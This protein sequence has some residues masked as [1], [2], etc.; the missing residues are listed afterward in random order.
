MP[1][2][3]MV[4]RTPPAPVTLSFELTAGFSRNKLLARHTLTRA[5]Q[6]Q[7]LPLPSWWVRRFDASN[8]SRQSVLVLS[9]LSEYS[10]DLAFQFSPYQNELCQDVLPELAICCFCIVFSLGYQAHLAYGDRN[11]FQ[12]PENNL[13]PAKYHIS[14]VT[15]RKASTISR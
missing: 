9:L 5:T 13:T 2:P 10:N 12:R 15:D 8:Q 4:M 7:L 6:T 1:L 11:Q 3:F 14:S